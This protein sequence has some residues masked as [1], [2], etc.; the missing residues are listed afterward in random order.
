MT[1][2]DDT[3]M[4]ATQLSEDVKKLLQ[5]A[6]RSAMLM[7]AQESIKLKLTKAE[8]DV[9]ATMIWNSQVIRDHV[10]KVRVMEERI[11]RLEQLANGG[12]C[13]QS[14]D[15]PQPNNNNEQPTQ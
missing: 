11:A 10:N 12:P 7:E 14:L 8:I 1:E 2:T 4:T 5:D 3:D 9:M 13:T 15:E 6:A